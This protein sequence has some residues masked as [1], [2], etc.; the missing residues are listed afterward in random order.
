MGKTALY[1]TRNYIYLGYSVYLIAEKFYSYRLVR[2]T[3]GRENFKHIAPYPEL[4]TD[5]VH[6]VALV[7]YFNKPFD[8]IVTTAFLSLTDRKHIF[9]VILRTTQAVDTAYTGNDNYVPALRKC[10]RCRVAQAINLII[11]GA[12]F[13]DICIG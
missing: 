3:S 11:Y 8:Y 5:K 10:R 6:I 1:L 12:V 9:T 7:L 2:C 13:F 4:V